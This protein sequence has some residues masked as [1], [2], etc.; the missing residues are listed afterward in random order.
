MI[1]RTLPTDLQFVHAIQVKGVATLDM[2]K[3]ILAH[4]ALALAY[5]CLPAVGNAWHA[6]QAGLWMITSSPRISEGLLHVSL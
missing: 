5:F 1:G 2:A 6:G 3:L 4:C